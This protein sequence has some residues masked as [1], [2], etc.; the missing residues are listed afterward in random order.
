MASSSNIEAYARAG[1][2]YN[3]DNSSVDG[4]SCPLTGDP[5]EEKTLQGGIGVGF[6]NLLPSLTLA[7]SSRFS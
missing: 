7:P 3:S 1:T 5:V 4:L 2:P 6:S